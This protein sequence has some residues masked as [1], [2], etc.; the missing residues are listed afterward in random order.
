MMPQELVYVISFL[1]Y[2]YFKDGDATMSEAWAA[3][4][5]NALTLFYLSIVSAIVIG[6]VIFGA[7]SEANAVAG[8]LIAIVVAAVIIVLFI[9]LSMYVMTA[10]H[11]CLF[12]WARNVE[13]A[14]TGAPG[15]VKP[16]TPIANVMGV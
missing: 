11:T 8:A 9:A 2:D 14:G 13:D 4:K 6:F 15:I 16:P 12:L 3:V 1:V 7:M 10:Y 5:K